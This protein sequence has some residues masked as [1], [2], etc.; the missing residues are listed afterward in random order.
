MDQYKSFTLRI[1]I[2]L[3]FKK[4]KVSKSLIDKDAIYS[5]EGNASVTSRNLVIGQNVAFAGEYGISVEI[6]NHLRLMAI[7]NTLQIEEQNVVCRLSMDGI[8]PS[9]Q[10]Y[11]MI[12]FF[13]DKLS[14]AKARWNN[15]GM[16]CS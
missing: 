4:N 11:G 5:A 14:T 10:T 9:Y 15:W 7:E 1:L 13:R 6:L 12:D 8:T 2:L 16:G 3:Y